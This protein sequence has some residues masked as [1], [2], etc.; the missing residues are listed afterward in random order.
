MTF[1]TITDNSHQ[2]Y[3]YKR[4]KVEIDKEGVS[5]L[6][7]GIGHEK[8]HTVFK[9]RK[10]NEGILYNDVNGTKVYLDTAELPTSIQSAIRI[11]SNLK[12]RIEEQ[13]NKEKEAD[14]RKTNYTDRYI[15]AISFGT[16]AFPGYAYDPEPAAVSYYRESIK[17]LNSGIET[18]SSRE[19][20]HDPRLGAFFLRGTRKQ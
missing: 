7:R 2:E 20:A 18:L 16:M 15:A 17:L 13:I 1:Q 3:E 12:N 19:P 5:A 11:M 9:I 10:T 8:Y 4:L 6:H 14:L